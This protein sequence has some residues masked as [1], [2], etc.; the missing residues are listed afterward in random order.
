[1]DKDFS[2]ACAASIL[3]NTKY[4]VKIRVKKHYFFYEYIEQHSPADARQLHVELYMNGN[5]IALALSRLL[6]RCEEIGS[7]LEDSRKQ[8]ADSETLSLGSRTYKQCGDL[9]KCFVV[10]TRTL[11]PS[12]DHDRW[13]IH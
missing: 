9:A 6:S 11:S 5:C 8:N 1:M 10:P 7:L 13:L 4:D 2:D 3:D 12:S